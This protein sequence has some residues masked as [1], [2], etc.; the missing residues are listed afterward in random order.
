MR[1]RKLT[2]CRI[3]KHATYCEVAREKDNYYPRRTEEL[4]ELRYEEVA[5]EN[6]YSSG[7]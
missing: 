7:V 2:H 6:L 1:L 5:N 4:K 3:S